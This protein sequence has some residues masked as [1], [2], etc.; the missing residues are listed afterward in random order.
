MAKSKN[1]S[2]VGEAVLVGAGIAAVAAA[3]YFLTGK[4]GEKNRKHLRGWAVKMKG[5]VLE[6]LEDAKEV[7]EPIYNNIVDTVAKTSVV[8]GAVSRK[9]IME[10]ADQL[11][12][13]WKAITRAAKGASKGKKK[14]KASTKKTSSVKSSK[15]TAKKKS[16]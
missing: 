14:S 1:T 7:T 3:T 9:E 5:E 10:L 4:K 2:K 16:K 12:K 15:K 13:D 6:K 11:K 8:A